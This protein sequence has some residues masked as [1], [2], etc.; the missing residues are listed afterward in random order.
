GKF[1]ERRL[2]VAYISVGDHPQCPVPVSRGRREK[3]GQAVDRLPWESL[4]KRFGLP[5]SRRTFLRGAG[6]ALALPWLEAMKPARVLCGEDPA[7]APAA[8]VRMAVLFMPNGVHPNEWTPE[9]EGRAFCLSPILEPLADFQDDLMVL[10]NL[11]HK[12]CRTG[13][14][15]YVKT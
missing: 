13:D 14:G 7:S 11:G 4:M 8:P 3:S 1:E 5:L 15:H 9:G 6:A 10:T 2:Q 12:A